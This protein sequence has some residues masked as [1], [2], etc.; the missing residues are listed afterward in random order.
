MLILDGLYASVYTNDFNRAI[1]V[2]RA[3]ESGTVAVNSTS[4]MLAADM[5]R[6]LS[7]IIKFLICITHKLK[8]NLNFHSPLVATKQVDMAEKWDPMR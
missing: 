3:L 6:L 5:V 7:Y 2:S 4:P 8:Y 1:R